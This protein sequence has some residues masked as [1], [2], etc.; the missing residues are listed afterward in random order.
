M[1]VLSLGL[2]LTLATAFGCALLLLA[3]VGYVVVQLLG[4]KPKWV[5]DEGEQAVYVQVRSTD[6]VQ[7]ESITTAYEINQSEESVEDEDDSNW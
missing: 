3:C 5:I 1:G 2:A 6:D 4:F 7:L